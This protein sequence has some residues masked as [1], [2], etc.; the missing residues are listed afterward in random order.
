[1]SRDP[2]L[3]FDDTIVARATAPGVAGV[4]V[5]RLSGPDARRILEAMA[6]SIPNSHE[7]RV[8]TLRS[9][10]GEV[11]DDALVVF[12]AAP[13]SYTGE[14]VVEFQLHGSPV[15][16]RVV[17]ERCL[18]LGAR[19]AG[20]GEFTQ[21]AFVR[22][23]L[24]LAQAEAVADL[25][26]AASEREA[27]AAARHLSGQLSHEITR[28]LD[29]V[30]KVVSDWRA[31]LDFPE[32]PTDEGADR[33]REERLGGVLEGLDALINR[34]RVRVQGARSVVVCGPPN[35]GKSTLVNRWVGEERVLVH[36]APGTT[37]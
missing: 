14:D 22:G 13:N 32:Y 19:A 16:V 20:P 23:R 33:A 26:H 37:R 15:V 25:I 29:S 35:A 28:H 10:T 2:H 18:G 11:I 27:N 36:D 3:S 12:M 7:L 1:M 21:R 30:E 4:A 9:E 17:L 34:A 8:R 6:G 24:D 5:V 31:A